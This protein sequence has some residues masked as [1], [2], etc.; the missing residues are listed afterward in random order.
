MMTDHGVK[1]KLAKRVRV[2]E[3]QFQAVQPS[4][5]KSVTY[6]LNLSV[7]IKKVRKNVM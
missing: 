4:N 7:T 6:K 5:Q 3:T 1:E 2:I